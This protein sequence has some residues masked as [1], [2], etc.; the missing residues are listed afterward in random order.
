MTDHHQ[1]LQGRR[2]II[3]DTPGFDDTCL[4]DAEILRRIA[5]WLADSYVILT[6]DS[7]KYIVVHR[8][9]QEM[10]LGGV[11]YLHRITDNRMAGTAEKNLKV[12]EKLCGEKALSS[13]VLA[14]T[15]WDQVQVDDGTLRET[16]LTN[17]YWKKMIEYGSSTFRFQ[18][19]RQSAQEVIDRILGQVENTYQRGFLQIQEE[20]VDFER[21]I[22]ETKAG[23]QLRSTLQNLLEIEH[24]LK[25]ARH[26]Q[27]IESQREELEDSQAEICKRLSKQIK[28]LDVSLPRRI[29]AFL[30]LSVSSS[31]TR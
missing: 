4:S 29:L 6:S 20:I 28:D 8:Y 22:P 2:I 11:I 15:H 25:M 26:G 1:S 3:V 12:F 31:P 9:A 24:K 13:V 16:A 30:R 17:A 18:G 5:A 23:M 14:T 10:K 7:N 27:G 19:T 21:R